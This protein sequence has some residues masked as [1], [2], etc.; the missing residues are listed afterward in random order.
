[1]ESYD[2]IPT[3]DLLFNVSEIIAFL[4]QST[5]L[6]R[7]TVIMTGTPSGVAMGM[8]DQKYLQ[9]GDEV[10]VS[11]TQIGTLVNKMRFE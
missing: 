3:S 1:M 7:G 8:K 2:K 11:I 4:S 9:D 6:E 5:T 10:E